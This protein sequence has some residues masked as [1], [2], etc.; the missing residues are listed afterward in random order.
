MLRKTLI[1]LATILIMAQIL[2]AQDRKVALVI[3]N[4]AYQN[5]PTLQNPKNDAVDMA[6]ALGKLGFEVIPVIN[7]T[8]ADMD[9]AIVQFSRKLAGAQAGLFFYAGHGV[10]SNGLNYLLPVDVKIEEEFQLKQK[11]LDASYVLDAMNAANVPINVV[12]LD[13]CRD[14]PWKKSGRTIGGTRGL[15]VI[16]NVPRGTII[17]YSTDPGSI[18]QDGT[19]KNGTFTAA[20]LKHISTP[21]IDVKEMF[22]RVGAE[23]SAETDHAQNPWINSM[24]YGKFYLGGTASSSPA[25]AVVQIEPAATPTITV[26]RSYGSLSITTAS[27]GTLFLDGKAMGD[28]PAG[29]KAKLDSVEVGD[30]SLEIHYADGQVERHSAT[31]AEGESESVSFIYKKASRAIQASKRI[32]LVIGNAAYS[33]LYPLRTPVNDAA[34]MA[35]AL[36]SIGF[37]VVL[38]TNA[39]MGAMDGLIDQF[40]NDI[41]GADIALFYYSGYGVQVGDEN[42]LLPVTAK[43]TVAADLQSEAVGIARLFQRMRQGGA[44][45]NAIILDASRDNPFRQTSRGLE[46]GITIL[47]GPPPETIIVYATEAGENAEDGMGRNSVFTSALLRNIT[48]DEEFTRILRDVSAQV[49][50]ET[51]QRQKPTTF[52]NLTHAVHLTGKGSSQE[53]PP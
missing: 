27:A 50:T 23:V 17:V 14:N 30:R 41:N 3:G 34:D 44:G 11:A 43:I 12:I 10:Q 5:V 37:E 9:N 24:F 26:S 20:L 13:A 49:R 6:T 22:D 35:A 19:G 25:P 47:G 28:L 48:R 8:Y 7:G 39:N 15:T 36:K 52:S 16:E 40:G 29:A 18:A 1:P 4:S 32:A 38:G 53:S 31:V 33:T 45:T 2:S 51:N 42:Y 46:R 21:G